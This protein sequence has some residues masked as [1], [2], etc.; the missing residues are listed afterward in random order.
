[1]IS[2]K[3]I[4][5]LSYAMAAY[6]ADVPK[7]PQFLGPSGGV[8]AKDAAPP[9]E[10]GPTRNVAWKVESGV[11]HGSPCIW[12]DRIFLLSFDAAAKKFVTTAF[13]R[14]KGTVLWRQGIEAKE[15]EKVHA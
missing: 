8:A 1:M 5:L 7:W 9:V 10:F 2:V 4:L 11:G 15:L 12:G 14:A 6:A 13:D 3:C